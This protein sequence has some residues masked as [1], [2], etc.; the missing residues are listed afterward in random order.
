V[1]PPPPR[2]PYLVAGFARSGRAAAAALVARGERV[3]AYDA[4]ECDP[5]EGIELACGGQGVE[6][7]ERVACV[8]KS[9]GV[10]REAPLIEAALARGVPVIGEVELAWRL[11]P[12]E[13]IAVTGTNGKT[14]TVELIGEIHRAAG[15]P[16]EVA[17]NVGRALSTLLPAPPAPD[18]TIVCEVSSFQ[19]EDTLAFAPDAA[20]LLNLTAD[21]L[22]RH[23][24]FE[25]YRGAKLRIFANQP[26]EAIAVVPEEL[27]ALATGA[28]QAVLFG[29]GERCAL[30]LERGS[31]YWQDELLLATTELRMRAPLEDAMA[32][33]AVSL[34]RGV[35]LEAVHSAL[36][37]FR[38]VAHRLEEIS[39]IGGV[40]YVNDSKATNIAS[41]LVALA[42]FEPGSVLLILG[43]RGKGQDFTLLREAVAER[44]AHVYVIGEDGPRIAD[45]LAGLPCTR[46]ETLAE[47]VEHAR[48]LAHRGQV[49][50][51]SPACASFDQFDDFE[52]RGDAFRMLVDE[53]A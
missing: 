49:V 17:G 30:R 26:A 11:L 41:T 43:G 6:L 29:A 27:A 25:R 8:V 52:A 51:L 4:G 13:L 31:L 45:A 7:L 1:R 47:A 5:L 22:D 18:A 42:A 39:Q 53:Q 32:A 28:A 44:A 12:N 35:S 3:I 21:H 40:T 37:A 36:V 46:V 24:S 2:G 34:A 9:P 50:L 23:H 16:V 33:A 19:L 10:P 38:G 15:A 14:T 48:R 20:V